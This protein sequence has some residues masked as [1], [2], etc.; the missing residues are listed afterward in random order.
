MKKILMLMLCTCCEAANAQIPNLVK[1]INP[2]SGYPGVDYLFNYNGKILFSASDGVHGAELWCSNGTSST[3]YMI[4]DICS[5]SCSSAPWGFATL[6]GRVLFH[7]YQSGLWKTDGTAAGTQ[8]VSSVSV[9]SYFTSFNNA[10]YF[11]GSNSTYGNELWKTDGTSAGTVMVKDI[12]TGT[13][14]SDIQFIDILNGNLIFLANDG[15]H[16]A[17]LWKTDGTT[18]GT[19]M[20]RD[21][22][23]GYYGGVNPYNFCKINT[24]LFFIGTEDNGSSKLYKTDG[25]TTG[26][27]LVKDISG[28]SNDPFYNVSDPSFRNVNGTLVFVAEVY[29]Y[30][31]EL[32]KS[33]GTDPSTTLLK[34]INP[35]F[36]GSSPTE[37]T[38]MNG[39][40]YFYAGD[41]AG[42]ELWRSNG[43]TAGTYLVKDIYPSITWGYGIQNIMAAN[44]LLYFTSWSANGIELYRS[45]G[46]AGGTI[47]VKDIRPGSEDSYPESLFYANGNLYFTATS[48]TDSNH[49]LWKTDGTSAGTVLVRDINPGDTNESY[50]GNFFA[51]SNR[52]Y[53]LA[54]DGTHGYEL[55][56][57]ALPVTNI[58]NRPESG[59]DLVGT[60]SEN[61]ISVYPNP[62]HSSFT[63]SF[64][65]QLS[66]VNSHLK[67]YDVMGKMVYEQT[68]INPK[69][70]ISNSLLPGI[71]FVQVESGDKVYT[72]K[73]VIE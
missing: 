33:D 11:A 25:T 10:L 68:I 71:Y 48:I 26:T 67:I 64:N 28:G 56:T 22:Y 62:A 53:F 35:S 42:E 34:D 58:P 12:Y 60:D 7:T 4:K 51:T 15:V 14:G 13:T 8:Q 36:D 73:L 9:N 61:S 20:I 72:K 30:G 16:G 63:L 38:M 52:L 32:W 1:D 21:L 3:T 55:W 47:M 54:D 27:V 24:T 39:I 17:E 49:E 66:S 45:N 46:T 57:M 40:V 70:E 41:N 69:S 6:N 43:T 31:I 65:D 37:L 23:P 2:G 5:G 18:A 44:N 59:D 29:P 50:P 19:V